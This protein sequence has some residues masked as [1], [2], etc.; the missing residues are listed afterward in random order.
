LI[1][2]V[3]SSAGEPW[4]LAVQ[5]HP[6]EMH[7]DTRAPEQGLFAAMVRESGRPRGELVR[8]R[9]EEQAVAHGVQR[10]S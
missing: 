3:E 9:R 6:E 1:E 2:V 8:E 7:K 5:W 10:T 4:L